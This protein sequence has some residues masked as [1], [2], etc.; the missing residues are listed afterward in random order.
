MMSS[1][2]VRRFDLRVDQGKALDDVR[3]LLRRLVAQES[4][5]VHAQIKR[6][7]ALSLLEVRLQGDSSAISRVVA[8]VAGSPTL[9]IEHDAI[10]VAAPAEPEHLD[11]GR[12]GALMR[13]GVEPGAWKAPVDP[14]TSS[15]S[16][17]V[18]IVDS[19]IMVDHPKLK[20]H[21]WA[22][23]VD[24]AQAHGARCIDGTRSRDVTDRDGH[25]TRLAGTIL[26]VTQGAP[27]V[28]LMAVKF[29]D[30]DHLPGPENGAAGIDFAVEQHAD[31][32][33][34]S[35]DLG[36]GSPALERAIQAAYDAG[37]LVVIA[38]GNSGTDNDVIPTIPACYRKGREKR[39]ITVMATDR[40]D[41]KAS[42]SNYG[43]GTV[44][45]AAPGV[46]LVTTRAALTSASGI[47]ARQYHSFTGTSAAAATVSG[48]AALLM[49]RD[50]SLS[51]D[52]RRTAEA[53]KEQLTSSANPPRGLKCVYGR[54]NVV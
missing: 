30:A 49:S 26:S 34:L 33:N 51:R 28:R 21:L 2:V 3:D 15:P 43:I 37:A 41:D 8:Q 25:G 12:R 14:A 48:A 50:P 36:M 9:R 18:A 29:F 17:T 54:L 13:I 5:I 39:I 44:D 42:F 22:G 16:V 24:G 38:A 6:V 31:I 47:G 11:P 4:G 46:D 10:R 32:I 53:L 23:T 35:W 40:Y 52:P 20:D 19:G 45:L 1:T 27:G 7:E